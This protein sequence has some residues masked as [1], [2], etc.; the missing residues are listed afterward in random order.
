M[1][2]DVENKATLLPPN[3]LYS[4]FLNQDPFWLETSVYVVHIIFE[5]SIGHIAWNTLRDEITF[6]ILFVGVPGVN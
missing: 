2:L 1:E 5:I 3:I 4:N 6:L